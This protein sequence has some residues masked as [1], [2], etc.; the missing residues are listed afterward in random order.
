MLPQ[1]AAA[2]INVSWEVATDSLFTDVVKNG[3]YATD[4]A[5]YH[6]IKVR[7]KG[8]QPDQYYYYR[9]Q[10]MNAESITGRTKTT[11]SGNTDELRFAVVSCNN[12]E[13]GYFVAFDKVAD[14]NDLDAVLHLG[15]YIYEYGPGVYGDATNRRFHEPPYEIVTWR[16]PHPLRPVS[17]G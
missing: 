2:S 1:E 4:S 8:L 11:P 13:G 15:D 10:A 16:L 6:T 5:N 17:P 12:Y 14:R 3:S 7:V 9:F